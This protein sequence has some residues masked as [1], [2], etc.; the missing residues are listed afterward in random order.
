V[1][2]GTIVQLV[3]EKRPDSEIKEAITFCISIGLPVSFYELTKDELTKDEIMNVA[4]TASGSGSFM[5]SEPFDVTPEMIFSALMETDAL[6]R[7][8][9]G[10]RNY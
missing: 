10:K 4:V 1:A 9:R 7:S 3:L 2:F 8:Y 6:G 5:E